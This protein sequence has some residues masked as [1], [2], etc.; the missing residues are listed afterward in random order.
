MSLRLL[1]FLFLTW[2]N[3]APKR[4]LAVRDSSP[5]VTRAQREALDMVAAAGDMR[6]VMVEP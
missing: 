6:V 2:I 4:L 1:P 3:A 5:E